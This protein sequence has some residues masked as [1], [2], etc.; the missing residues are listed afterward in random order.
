MAAAEEFGKLYEAVP[1]I[2][3]QRTLRFW[4]VRAV[5]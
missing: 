4:K 1:V 5:A 2:A 3:A